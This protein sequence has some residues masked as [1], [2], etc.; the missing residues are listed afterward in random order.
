MA[1][2]PRA[3]REAGVSRWKRLRLPFAIAVLGFLINLIVAVYMAPTG[4]E[5]F[6]LGYGARILSGVA[7]RSFAGFDS[8]MPI[9]ALNAIPRGLNK[10]LQAHGVDPA[11]AGKLRDVRFGRIA[12]MIAAFFLSLLVYLYAE[13]LYGR[14]AGLF[15]QVLF[16]LS[17]NI[18]AHSTL[19]TTDLYAAFTFVLF[20]YCLRRF[21]LDPNLVNSIL[22]AGALALAQVVKFVGIYLYPALLLVLLA[23]L[24]T[25]RFISLRQ[26]AA[27][28]VLHAAILFIVLN[29]AFL[30]D[31]TFTPLAGYKFR[32]AAFQSIQRIPLIR[33]IPLP[34]P[35][36]YV[37]GFDWIRYHNDN[38]ESFGNIVLLGDTRGPKLPRWDGFPSYYLVCYLLKEPL[39][40]QLLLAVSVV[41]LVRNRKRDPFLVGEFPL[42]AAAGVLVIMLSFFSRT[43]IGIRHILPALVVAV[44]L[45]GA[46]FSHLG[47]ASQRRRVFL[48]A[49][50][51]FTVVS[52]ASYFPNLIPYFNEIVPD[53][54]MAYTYLADSNL[55]WDQDLW[56]V[57]GFLKKHPD[58]KLNPDTPVSGWVLV[59]ANYMAGVR[60]LY[61]D[62]WARQRGLKPVAQV[63]YAHLLF[64]MPP[65]PEQPGRTAAPKSQSADRHNTYESE[66]QSP[67]KSK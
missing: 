15:S 53:R 19:A 4:D 9:S 29:I 14:T 32:S 36:P 2:P 21:L 65:G 37:Q 67:A 30:F 17:P 55:D 40:M 41:W 1:P 12:T 33:E 59:S 16:V 48:G 10:F 22:A 62:Y 63:G 54:K 57:E 50:L 56:V 46:A 35:Y 11:V 27:F 38:G 66:R 42:L 52:V 26:I 64:F 44:I 45:S 23:V 6:H 8:K 5:E 31:R 7:D 34:A 47:Q 60:P 18:I 28:V 20:L 51:L 61:A 49:C 3:S 58:V 39:G 13:S 24:F 43:Q 25:R